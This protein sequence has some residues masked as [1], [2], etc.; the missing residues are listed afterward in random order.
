MAATLKKLPAKK[1]TVSAAEL[2][3]GFQKDMGESVGSFGGS[4][5]NSDRI[6]TGLFPLDLALGGGFPRGRCSIIYG[7]ES[8]ATKRTSC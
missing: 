8:R 3:A 6:P 1:A 2:L 4:L 7:P 5:A